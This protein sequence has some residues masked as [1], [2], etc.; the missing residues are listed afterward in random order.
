[1]SS[2]KRDEPGAGSRLNESPVEAEGRKAAGSASSLRKNANVFIFIIGR[3]DRSTWNLNGASIRGRR[4]TTGRFVLTFRSPGCKRP[5][6]SK[7]SPWNDTVF[8]SFRK[9][10][11]GGG[12]DK[13]IPTPRGDI[14]ASNFYENA[15]FPCNALDGRFSVTWLRDRPISGYCLEGNFFFFSFPRQESEGLVENLKR[16]IR[17]YSIENGWGYLISSS[18]I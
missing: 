10:L 15:L 7:I 17:R 2:T 11:Q 14:N 4:V 6:R 13:S 18:L 12:T 16:G 9:S 8:Q 3:G 5:F 1:M